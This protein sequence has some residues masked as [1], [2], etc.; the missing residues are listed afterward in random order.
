MTAPF[1]M[2][3]HTLMIKHTNEE[4]FSERATQ[5]CLADEAAG[6]FL[7]VV[8]EYTSNQPQTENCIGITRE[9]WPLLKRAI[10]RMF[11]EIDHIEREE[12]AQESPHDP[13]PDRTY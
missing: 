4:I 8:Q 3:T 10:E 2:L 6:M 9:E 12:N 5:I 1:H 13:E 7:E 11:Q